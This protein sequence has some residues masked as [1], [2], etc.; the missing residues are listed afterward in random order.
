MSRPTRFA[1]QWANGRRIDPTRGTPFKSA[2]LAWPALVQFADQQVGERSVLHPSD[3][4]P[5]KGSRKGFRQ[6]CCGT[7][8]DS[9]R[10]YLWVPLPSNWSKLT[11]FMLG[12]G[13]YKA[14]ARSVLQREGR[15]MAMG[16]AAGAMFELL[17]VLQVSYFRDPAPYWNRAMEESMPDHM[18]EA[19][20]WDHYERVPLPDAAWP[21]WRFVRIPAGW[22]VDIPPHEEGDSGSALAAL[23]S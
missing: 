9:G 8:S 17:E 18:A 4:E 5:Y 13:W 16:A 3:I 19:L 22:N 7:Y 10:N 2:K 15:L 21:Y 23:L 20:W 1:G 12:V 14:R 6:S 11:W